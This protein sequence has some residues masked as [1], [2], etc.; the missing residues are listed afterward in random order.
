LE[1]I[2][3]TGFFLIIG[4][5]AVAYIIDLISGGKHQSNYVKHCIKDPMAPKPLNCIKTLDI[6]S[7]DIN[8]NP[9]GW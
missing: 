7:V 5:F 2:K 9:F 4:F 6:T 1:E 8:K 3:M